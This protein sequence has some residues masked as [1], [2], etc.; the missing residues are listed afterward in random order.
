MLRVC[1]LLSFGLHAVAHELCFVLCVC[2]LRFEFRVFE[3]SSFSIE[4]C[5]SCVFGRSE[6][7]M[8]FPVLF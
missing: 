5:V 3:F 8:M 1:V 2:G 7:A 4:Y 6:W